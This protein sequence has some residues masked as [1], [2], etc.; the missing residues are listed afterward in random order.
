MVG[1]NPPEEIN[2][3]DRFKLLNSLIS[4]IDNNININRV[5]EEYRKKTFKEVFLKFIATFELLSGLK[6]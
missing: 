4:K 3:I 5:E 1:I 6:T 2:V